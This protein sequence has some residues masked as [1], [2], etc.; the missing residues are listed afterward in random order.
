MRFSSRPPW[1]AAACAVLLLTSMLPVPAAAQEMPEQQAP[2]PGLEIAHRF[3][4]LFLDQSFKE[5]RKLMD[6]PMRKAM[7]PKEARRFAEMIEAQAGKPGAIGEAWLRATT[8]VYRHFIVPVEYERDD[9][10]FRVVLDERE[11]VAGFY[12]V[13]PDEQTPGQVGGQGTGGEPKAT[14][15]EP[16]APTA[17][18]TQPDEKPASPPPPAGAGPTAD[19]LD[20]LPLS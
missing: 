2:D 17:S 12:L 4:E 9:V 15:A 7:T 1:R 14:P 20:D 18:G 6:P 16:D 8:G 19:D 5:A 3:V 10:R 13:A 11:Q